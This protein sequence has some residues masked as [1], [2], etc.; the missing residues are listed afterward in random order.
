MQFADKV[1]EEVGRGGGRGKGK[2]VN[3]MPKLNAKIHMFLLFLLPMSFHAVV[4]GDKRQ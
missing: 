2:S 1:K 4:N 3:E